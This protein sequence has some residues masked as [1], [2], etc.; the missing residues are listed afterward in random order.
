MGLAVS[1]KELEEILLVDFHR[2]SFCVDRFPTDPLALGLG[3]NYATGAPESADDV[4]RGSTMRGRRLQLEAFYMPGDIARTHIL[5]PC[6]D[7]HLNDRAAQCE[8]GSRLKYIDQDEWAPHER[9]N[10]AELEQRIQAI[11]EKW[12]HPPFCY[13]EKVP[14]VF[15]TGDRESERPWL[16]KA[17]KDSWCASLLPAGADAAK[18][19]CEAPSA[20]SWV[21]H[22][23]EDN[24]RSPLW[25]MDDKRR[26]A[27]PQWQQKEFIDEG[28]KIYGSATVQE[29][30]VA[31]RCSRCRTFHLA[32]DACPSGPVVPLFQQARAKMREPSK[33]TLRKLLDRLRRKR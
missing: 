17:G 33:G 18:V 31:V 26:A 8:H 7:C 30:A 13:V 12:S 3:L 29:H 19:F 1:E 21:K 14:P 2:A 6:N 20:P 15:F 27:A 23:L 25:C 4:R 11:F 24:R 32:E 5:R 9:E 28:G 10:Y 16:A 22:A